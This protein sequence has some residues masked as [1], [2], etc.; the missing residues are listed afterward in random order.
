MEATRLLPKRG[1][2]QPNNALHWTPPAP[3]SY[4]L[5]KGLLVRVSPVSLAVGPRRVGKHRGQPFL[6]AKEIEGANDKL[7]E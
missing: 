5:P 3:L 1:T 7:S 4:S 6:E 2:E